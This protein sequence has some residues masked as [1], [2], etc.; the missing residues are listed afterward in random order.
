MYLVLLQRGVPYQ[1]YIVMDIKAE[2]RTRLAP[3]L[4]DDEVIERVVL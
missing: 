3:R 4:I 1:P 2:Q